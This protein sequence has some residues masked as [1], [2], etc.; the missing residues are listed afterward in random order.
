MA[1]VA[2]YIA[3]SV[4]QMFSLASAMQYCQ[5]DFLLLVSVVTFDVVEVASLLLLGTEEGKSSCD[6]DD[7]VASKGDD[8]YKPAEWAVCGTVVINN[9][10]VSPSKKEE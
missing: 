5:C 6:A 1:E 7:G 8:S 3:G 4:R 10:Y 2:R 9:Y